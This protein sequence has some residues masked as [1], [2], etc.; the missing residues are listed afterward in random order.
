MK[1]NE[2]QT[3]ISEISPKT[4]T[5]EFLPDGY[6]RKDFLRTAGSVALFAALG[7]TFTSC[8]S[9]SEDSTNIVGGNLNEPTGGIV[10]SGNTITIDI[11]SSE[12]APIANSGGWLLIISAQT[13]VVNV[14]GNLVRAFTSICPHASCDRNWSYQNDQFR[15]TCHNSLFTNA[16]VRV[17]GP[18][19]R[20]LAEFAVVKSGNT[21][22]IT[23]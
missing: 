7:I 12:G 18:A 16:G 1:P 9:K 11:T 21:V 4:E 19:T 15:C 13:L 20:N 22:T 2:A 6:T 17:S 3:L 5:V 23:K 8:S 10:V 14:D